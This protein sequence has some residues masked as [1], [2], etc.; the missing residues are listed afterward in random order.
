MSPQDIRNLNEKKRWRK[1]SGHPRFRL[2]PQH[3][4]FTCSLPVFST[5]KG[6]LDC[7]RRY[8]KKKKKSW[9][10]LKHLGLLFKKQ[11]LF[12]LNTMRP[13]YD[14]SKP[15]LTHLPVNRYSY[16]IDI[17]S[18]IIHLHIEMRIKKNGLR[19]ALT[20]KAQKSRVR[21]I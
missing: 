10:L 16:Q 9:K 7:W 5:S 19:K 8:K 12:L 2:I 21:M 1:W 14:Q 18:T 3:V 15:P 11:R 6:H 13:A 4:S 17:D 20:F